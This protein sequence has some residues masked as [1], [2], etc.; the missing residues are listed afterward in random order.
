L[1]ELP[2]MVNPRCMKVDF[3]QYHS[4]HGSASV[5]FQSWL[6]RDP[7]KSQQ[8]PHNKFCTRQR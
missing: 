5:F 6:R 2:E 4:R 1:M 3:S 8:I 7:W